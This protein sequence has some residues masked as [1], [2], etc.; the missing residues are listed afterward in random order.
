MDPKESGASSAA[1]DQ[2]PAT[3]SEPQDPGIAAVAAS[4]QPTS[5]EPAVAQKI[6]DRL[7]MSEPQK[8]EQEKKSW[9]EQWKEA[10]ALREAAKKD[11]KKDGHIL[12]NFAVCVPC[13]AVLC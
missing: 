12:K 1:K 3:Q 7:E 6:E 11:E 5:Q 2:E 4:N 8:P 10:K 13:L 9:R